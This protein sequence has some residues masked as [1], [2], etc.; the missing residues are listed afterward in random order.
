MDDMFDDLMDMYEDD[1]KIDRTNIQR[2][3]FGMPGGKHKSLSRLMPHLPYREKWVDLFTGTGIVSLNRRH[4]KKLN[5]MNDR[6]SGITNFY[7]C[8]QDPVKR[9]ALVTWLECTCAS[10]EMFYLARAEWCKETDD[11]V[12]AAKWYY[13]MRSSVIGKGAAFARATNSRFSNVLH[14]SL[15]LF[16]AIHEHIKEKFIVE[17]LDFEQ[18]HKDYDSPDTVFY[19]DSP[20]IGTD[21]GIYE[22]KWT[23]DDTQRLLNTVGRSKGFC[24]VSGYADEQIDGAGFWDQR[25]VWEV[26]VNAEVRSFLPENFKAGLEHVQ[27]V[28]TVQEVLW[29]KE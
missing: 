6:Y 24:A 27:K 10:R 14:S 8:I 11:V 15:K 28:D 23:R 5:V 12:R 13:M 25:H 7:R 29:I 9:E 3:P 1:V 21:P 19:L 16:G 2:A 20:Y 17:N 4:S 26:S 22:H 18:C